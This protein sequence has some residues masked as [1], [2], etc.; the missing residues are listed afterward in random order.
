[1]RVQLFSQAAQKW[2][3]LLYITSI[4]SHLSIMIRFTSSWK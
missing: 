3:I 1:M 2:D 4:Y